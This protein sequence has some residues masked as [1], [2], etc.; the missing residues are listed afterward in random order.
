MMTTNIQ[1]L[2]KLT[3]VSLFFVLTACS[4]DDDKAIVEDEWQN[5]EHTYDIVL[6]RGDE[7]ITYSATV[8][9][10]HGVGVYE[11]DENGNKIIHL[12][13]Q[14]DDNLDIIGSIILDANDVPYDFDYDADENTASLLSIID[15]TKPDYFAAASGPIALSNFKIGP[16]H[17]ETVGPLASYKV[18]IEGVFHH[19]LPSGEFVEYEF[20][21]KIVV[22]PNNL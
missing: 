6:K 13:I 3:F 18:E 7:T 22:S 21:G 4:S 20:N 1:K 9:A 2:L 14:P 11:V 17:P 15:K 8:P 16:E 5:A 12:W 10:K 19:Y